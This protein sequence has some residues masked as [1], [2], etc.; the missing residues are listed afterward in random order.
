MRPD[1]LEPL[2]EGDLLPLPFRQA[3][4]EQAPDFQLR[5]EGVGAPRPIQW[6]VFIVPFEKDD[7]PVGCDESERFLNTG[8]SDHPWRGDDQ[9]RQEE[10]CAM[11]GPSGEA[12]TGD[13]PDKQRHD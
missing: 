5:V 10:Y 1:E 6:G 8:I 3:R 2:P 11:P 12:R 9:E 13:V 4:G 7:A